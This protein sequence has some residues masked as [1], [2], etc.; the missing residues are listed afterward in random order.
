MILSFEF[1][2]P[3]STPALTPYKQ[4]YDM[5]VNARFLKGIKILIPEGHKGLARLRVSVAGTPIAPA[6]GSAT[7]WIRGENSEVVIPLS[8]P[9]F[10]PPYNLFC[11]GYNED[12]FLPHTFVITVEC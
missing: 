7:Q 8:L 9:V 12:S 10:G 2:I 5:G 6:Q 11:E 4:I 3:R 1:S